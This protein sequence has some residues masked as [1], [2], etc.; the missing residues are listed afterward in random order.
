MVDSRP[1]RPDDGAWYYGPLVLL[2]LARPISREP[3]NV[4]EPRSSLVYIGLDLLLYYKLALKN[5]TVFE[6]PLDSLLRC[7][8]TRSS[9]PGLRGF[10]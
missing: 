8:G 1:Y 2:P 10:K 9:F 3:T 6:I 4:L 5:E 7:Q